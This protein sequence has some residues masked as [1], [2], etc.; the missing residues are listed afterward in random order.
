MRFEPF[1]D[2]KRDYVETLIK[3]KDMRK[4]TAAAFKTED[5]MKLFV[6]EWTKYWKEQ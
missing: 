4:A 6:G 1:K 5:N 3:T 2:V